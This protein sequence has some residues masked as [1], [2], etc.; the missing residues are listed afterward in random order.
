MVM[1]LSHSENLLLHDVLRLYDPSESYA[2]GDKVFFEIS[3]NSFRSDSSGFSPTQPPVTA[4]GI[5]EALVAVPA[6]ADG[7]N[8]PVIQ[9]GTT[10]G[11]NHVHPSWGFARESSPLEFSVDHQYAAGVDVFRILGNDIN[12]F[13]LNERVLAFRTPRAVT[14]AT[15][16]FDDNGTPDNT[17]LE[18]PEVQTLG[19]PKTVNAPY[20]LTSEDLS[21]NENLEIGHLFSASSAEPATSWAATERYHRGALV[22]FNNTLYRLRGDF[23]NE[24]ANGVDL[25]KVSAVTPERDRDWVVIGT[26]EDPIVFHEDV[27]ATIAELDTTTDYRWAISNTGEQVNDIVIQVNGVTVSSSI[28]V[29]HGSTVGSFN[30]SA[31]DLTT[32]QNAGAASDPVVVDLADVSTANPRAPFPVRGV[33]FG[34]DSGSVVI[35]EDGQNIGATHV[36]NVHGIDATA[37]DNRIDLTVIPFH[38]NEIYATSDFPSS[39]ISTATVTSNHSYTL[40]VFNRTGADFV[41]DQGQPAGAAFLSIVVPGIPNA[42]IPDFVAEVNSPIT[43]LVGSHRYFGGQ[44]FVF[45][46]VFYRVLP[47]QEYTAP[48]D[49]TTNPADVNTNLNAAVDGTA[50]FTEAVLERFTQTVTV[51]DNTTANLKF[52]ISEGQAA[53]IIAEGAHQD[54][55]YITLNGQRYPVLHSEENRDLIDQNTSRIDALEGRIS[56]EQAE[57][58]DLKEQLDDI[59]F[60]NDVTHFEEIAWH[61]ADRNSESHN[62]FGGTG[63]TRSGGRDGS[64]FIAEQ[65]T[66]EGFTFLPGST[67]IPSGTLTNLLS[68]VDHTAPVA[69]FGFYGFD[70]YHRYAQLVER[71]IP[72]DARNFEVRLIAGAG[73]TSTID[74]RPEFA[75]R[76]DPAADTDLWVRPRVGANNIVSPVTVYNTV[77]GQALTN[78]N[79]ITQARYDEA[80]RTMMFLDAAGDEVI[81]AGGGPGIEITV[82]Y[83]TDF[84]LRNFDYNRRD[85][86]IGLYLLNM[87]QRQGQ[88]AVAPHATIR[89]EFFR[90]IVNS[91]WRLRFAPRAEISVPS[92]NFLLL[93]WGTFLT[94]RGSL[95]ATINVDYLT[96]QQRNARLGT[97]V[98]GPGFITP[99]G[100]AQPSPAQVDNADRERGGLIAPDD[101]IRIFGTAEKLNQL[102]HLLSSLVNGTDVLQVEFFNRSTNDT[103]PVQ[104][105]DIVDL[106]VTGQGATDGRVPGL[107]RRIDNSDMRIPDEDGVTGDAQNPVVGVSY[108]DIMLTNRGGAFAYPQPGS[109]IRFF[110]GLGGRLRRNPFDGAPVPNQTNLDNS[111]TVLTLSS[112][113]TQADGTEVPTYEWSA[114][115][116][117]TTIP[118]PFDAWDNA[119]SEGVNLETV[120]TNNVLV[121]LV[122]PLGN[123]NTQVRFDNA[124]SF[125]F[126]VGDYIRLYRDEGATD[127]VQEYYRILSLDSQTL[128]T[129][130]SRGDTLDLSSQ[131]PAVERLPTALAEQV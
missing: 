73:Q 22:V 64:S 7:S 109:G 23:L 30:I 82:E 69:N 75:G 34:S 61:I 67:N 12:H 42:I 10:A 96:R 6:M 130:D 80:A 57:I 113:T 102:E 58:T 1:V 21:V 90:A 76:G 27:P 55:I 11:E 83:P 114:P 54:Q 46:N 125:T 121:D 9:R 104:V 33:P 101:Q 97:R 24:D 2:V 66:L 43:E 52:F 112:F 15:D 20:I 91:G 118:F 5:F 50:P 79:L 70:G 116:G 25:G 26:Q 88:T 131:V 117:V 74:L 32:I 19:N 16:P 95:P 3:A 53:T 8:Q 89:T 44:E 77:T 35:E 92:I 48:A 122:N 103:A 127:H 100:N 94:D 56:Q 49:L 93:T 99:I 129:V 87:N 72:A 105:T 78:L 38:L 68:F 37:T 124:P 59:L 111:E 14:R 115:G 86:E 65:I 110:T 17:R 84:D 18:R 62:S 71:N 41:I 4:R 106:S 36:L 51:A 119:I 128:F 28:N 81:I 31:A 40:D 60:A 13:T 123:G 63:Q 107:V 47:N 29:L 108:I 98:G 85:L 45:S 39:G 120:D 126:A